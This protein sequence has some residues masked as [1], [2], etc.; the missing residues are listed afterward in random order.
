MRMRA[1]LVIY[2]KHGQLAA[3]IDIR[4]QRGT[5]KEWATQLRSNL[6]AHGIWPKTPYFLVVGPDRIY[7]WKN[8]PNTPDRIE[9]DYE[10]DA[11]EFLKPHCER[12]G[13]PVEEIDVYTF[14]FLV[15]NWLINLWLFWLDATTEQ[16]PWLIESGFWDVLKD[17]QIAA[18]VDL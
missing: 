4:K 9:P 10:T 5:S 11:W 7:L 16:Q 18:E 13:V 12:L 6:F 1:N 17:G 2:D 3:I 15:G 8:A 14:E